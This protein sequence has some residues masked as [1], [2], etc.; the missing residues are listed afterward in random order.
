METLL[1]YRRIDIYQVFPSDIFQREYKHGCVGCCI[2]LVT[3]ARQYCFKWRLSVRQSVCLSVCVCACVRPKN[4]KK[5]THPNV[6]WYKYLCSTLERDIS[7]WP[8][9]LFQYFY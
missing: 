1:L 7:P 6:T 3:C 4:E 9:E 5:T 8:Q 2:G